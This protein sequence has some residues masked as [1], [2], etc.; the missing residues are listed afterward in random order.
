MGRTHGGTPCESHIMLAS[1]SCSQTSDLI[2][3]VKALDMAG[4]CVHWQEGQS[5]A[6]Q[7]LRGK[8]VTQDRYSSSW[9][10][11]ES[12]KEE[13]GGNAGRAA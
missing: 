3:C 11:Q 12:W 9:G 1:L 5:P 4:L 7:I 13:A 2:C 10:M 6:G 8:A